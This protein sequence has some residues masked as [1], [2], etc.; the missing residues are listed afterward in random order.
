MAPCMKWQDLRA[1]VSLFFGIKWLL[2]CNKCLL[3]GNKRLLSAVL[4][5]TGVHH[6]VVILRFNVT[7]LTL[8]PPKGIPT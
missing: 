1:I 2:L 7:L 5:S 4:K 3:F 8:L 6:I